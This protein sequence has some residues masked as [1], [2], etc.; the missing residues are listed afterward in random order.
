MAEFTRRFLINLTSGISPEIEE[1]W[2]ESTSFDATSS[3][4]KKTIK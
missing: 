3:S 1:C 2:S 4:I